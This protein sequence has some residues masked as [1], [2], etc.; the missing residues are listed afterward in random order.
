MLYLFADESY[1]DNVAYLVGG[2]LVNQSQI[3][4][5][6][7]SYDDII[8]KTNKAHPEVGLNIELHGHELFQR[9]GEWECLREKVDVAYAIYKRAITRIPLTGAKWTVRG[10]RQQGN[11]FE[12]YAF[13]DPPHLIAFTHLLE[14][15]CDQAG[16][17]P[18]TVIADMVDDRELYEE[19]LIFYKENGTPG[20]R[21]SK[22]PN[23]QFPIQWIDS[24]ESRTLQ[25]CDLATYI[26]YRKRFMQN[27]HFRAVAE[28]QKLRDIVLPAL[29]S[30]HGVWTP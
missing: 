24:K 1:L 14:R 19:R 10:V 29:Q 18:V 28:V 26:Y 21:S 22:L 15:I 23:I 7:R 20:Y 16:N 13:P 17:E 6:D 2:L 4:A 12:R 8:W 25:A 9:S 3:D 5:F 11:L 30:S 27:A